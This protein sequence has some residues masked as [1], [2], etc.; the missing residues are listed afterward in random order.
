MDKFLVIVR[1]GDYN[2]SDDSPLSEMGVK[3]MKKL[4]EVITTFVL[5]KAKEARQEN[6][7]VISFSFS[8]LERAIQ[9]IQELHWFGCGDI[10]I[11]EEGMANRMDIRQPRRI[12][13]KVMGLLNYYCA[14][15]IMIVAHG[16][17]PAV[18]TETAYEF[19]TGTEYKKLPY[20]DKACGFITNMSTGEVVPIRFGDLDKKAIPQP[21]VQEDSW[22]V[23][24]GGPG[25]LDD[26]IPF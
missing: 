14:D 20:V 3:Q 12:L 8:N 26:D 11:T 23:F 24:K 9:S 10:I 21:V 16:E 6:V 5:E 4:K 25:N 18:L 22:T 15:A 1:H 2:G 17:M 19:V 13:D 7:S